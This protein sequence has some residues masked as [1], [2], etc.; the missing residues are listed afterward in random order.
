VEFLEGEEE[1]SRIRRRKTG[2]ILGIIGIALLFSS[3]LSLR[4]VPAA[5]AL[6][7]VALIATGAGIIITSYFLVR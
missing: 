6:L 1:E 7:V 4:F 3:A 2:K 5:W